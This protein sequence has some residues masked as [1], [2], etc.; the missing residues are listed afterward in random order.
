[1]NCWLQCRCSTQDDAAWVQHTDRVRTY[2]PKDAGHSQLHSFLPPSPDIDEVLPCIIRHTRPS[3]LPLAAA[4]AAILGHLP[5]H[6][7]PQLHEGLGGGAGGVLNNK[8]PPAWECE[9]GTA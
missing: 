1:M 8:G 2:A 9:R 7:C 5:H 3:L 4:A 6:C